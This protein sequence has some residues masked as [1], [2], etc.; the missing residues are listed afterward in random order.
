M[1][2]PVPSTRAL[3]R[4]IIVVGVIALQALAVV[5]GYQTPHKVFSWQMFNASSDYQAEIVR[6]TVD[7]AR[8]DVRDPWPGGYRW[9]QLV[10]TRGLDF[11]FQQG[12]ADSGL[13]STL[14]F[15]RHAL[16]WVADHT[17]DDTE[18]RRLE[19]VVAYWDNGRGPYHVV[20]TTPDRLGVRP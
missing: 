13:D 8:H 18:T 20:F 12:H 9:E 5:R 14:D 15:L 3:L 2:G 1:N 19:A 7:G 10:Q 6:I 17:P 16:F 11:P 4:R